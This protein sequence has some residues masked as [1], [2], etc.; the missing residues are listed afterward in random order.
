MKRHWKGRFVKEK[1]RSRLASLVERNISRRKE[2][3]ATQISKENDQV[4]TTESGWVTGRRIVELSFLSD[5]LKACKNC[6]KPIYLHNISR[7]RVGYASIL[8]IPCECGFESSVATGKSHRPENKS[9]R[10]MPVYNIN[11]KAVLGK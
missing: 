5:Q 8:Y 1:K 2:A 3:S 11:T 6:T 4:E 9:R 7:E 10:G